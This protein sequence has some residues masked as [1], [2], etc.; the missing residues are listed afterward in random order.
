[1]LEALP[2]TGAAATGRRLGSPVAYALAVVVTVVAVLS[3]YFLPDAVP[4]LL[5]VYRSFFGDLFV[6]YGIP[7]LALAVLVGSRP[8]AGFVD[9]TPRA[10]VYGLAWY[11][12]LSILAIVAIIAL[13]IVYLVVDPVALQ[14]LTKVTPVIQ[15][16][17]SDPW[18]WV[19]FSFVI[20]LIEELIFRG[21]IFG[22]WL[23]RDP[24]RWVLHAGWTSAVFTGVHLY[25]GTTYGAATPLVVPQLFLLGFA[26]AAAMRA[27]GGNVL[28]VGILHGVNDAVAF[29]SLVN[30]DAALAVH[31]GIL[32]AGGAIALALY[33]RSRPAPRPVAPWATAPGPFGFAPP[34]DPYALL[35]AP[36]SSTILP[37]PPP[38]PPGDPPRG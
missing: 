36:G 34:R 32:L 3:Q 30:A 6:V 20:G 8:L 23:L 14:Q 16:A 13:T 22:Y 35:P 2:A 18:F 28:V 9:H 7:I 25:Y 1:M 5:P 33:L 37:P 17:K 29:Y 27:A 21:W 10:S 26:F 11:G 12:A 4:A 31:Y 38:P 15:S 19:V 24:D